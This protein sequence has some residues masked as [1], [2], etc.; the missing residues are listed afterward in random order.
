GSRLRRRIGADNTAGAWPIFNDE[1]LLERIAQTI[2]ERA[3]DQIG[4]T[5]SAQRHDYKECPRRGGLRPRVGP[6]QGERTQPAKQGGGARQKNYETDPRQPRAP[7][8]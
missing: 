8:P 2:C 5:A 4:G 7:Q 3:G 6:K 1:R